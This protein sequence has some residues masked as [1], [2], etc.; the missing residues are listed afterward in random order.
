[1]HDAHIS[2]VVLPVGFP[3]V[4]IVSKAIATS[5]ASLGFTNVRT[6]LCGNSIAHDEA[7]LHSIVDLLFRFRFLLRLPEVAAIVAA[8]HVAIES[9]SS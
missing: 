4:V 1:M 3:T 9:H 2:A 6:P 5:S 8:T 7:N